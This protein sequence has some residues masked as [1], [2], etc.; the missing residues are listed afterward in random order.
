MDETTPAQ[1]ISLA[2]ALPQASLTTSFVDVSDPGRHK[3]PLPKDLTSVSAIDLEAALLRRASSR[4]NS[5]LTPDVLNNLEL[6]AY[7]IRLLI[8]VSFSG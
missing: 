2:V 7:Y 8:A 1:E 6:A 3:T 5:T 4:V